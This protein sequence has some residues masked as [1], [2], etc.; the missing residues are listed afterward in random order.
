ME[1]ALLGGFHLDLEV[2]RQSFEALIDGLL[3]GTLAEVD[4]ALTE[5]ADHS[6]ETGRRVTR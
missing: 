2:S 6:G 4:R 5:T 3:A 1:E